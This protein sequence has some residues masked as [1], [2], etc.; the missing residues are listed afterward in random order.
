MT[1]E[2]NPKYYYIAGEMGMTRSGSF[3]RAK[4]CWIIFDLQE[5]QKIESQNKKPYGATKKGI[6][7]KI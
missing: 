1:I 5:K 4:Q 7:V 2:S 6:F 3:S